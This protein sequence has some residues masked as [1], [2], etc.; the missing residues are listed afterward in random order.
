[1]RTPLIRLALFLAVLLAADRLSGLALVRLSR[2]V[3]VSGGSPGYFDR[4]LAVADPGTLVLGS[5]QAVHG[6]DPAVI[7]A[8]TG[9]GC[10]NLGCDGQGVYSYLVA[11]ASIEETRARPGTVVICCTYDDLFTDRV[12][13]VLRF[14]G[15]AERSS[16][17]RAALVAND[18]LLP[19]KWASAAYRFNAVNPL[20]LILERLRPD[21]ERRD[22]GFVPLDMALRSAATPRGDILAVGAFRP[23]KLGLYA[24]L[25]ERL[26][27][28]G[29]RTVLAVL[30]SHHP[31]IAVPEEDEATRRW[32]DLAATHG[33]E[34][35][36]LTAARFP[37]LG[38]AELY[39]D[40]FHL[41]RRGAAAL[42]ALLAAHLAG[43]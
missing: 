30:P 16:E 4:T 7:G 13:R 43:R 27:A 17:V 9:R 10:A 33:A 15:L 42:S 38:D 39:A 37:Q 28:T 24:A 23:D 1:M 26:R 32:E 22:D 36:A 18:A 12:E 31:D 34:F 41:N 11:L 8:A 3:A 19:L 6:I 14:G 5:S 20:A 25:L 29:I 35:I 21:P 2:G 40:T